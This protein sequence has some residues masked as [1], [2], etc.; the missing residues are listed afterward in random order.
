MVRQEHTDVFGPDLETVPA[1]LLEKPYLV[2]Q[3]PVT[4]AV[5]KET[6]RLYPPAGALRLGE[7]G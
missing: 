6:L 1:N 5:I 2:N 3:L 4:I 7:P